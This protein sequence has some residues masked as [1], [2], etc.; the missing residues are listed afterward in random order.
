[1]SAPGVGTIH[2]FTMSDTDAFNPSGL[3]RH[4]DRLLPLLDRTLGNSK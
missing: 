3:Q 4:W 2:G 1:M